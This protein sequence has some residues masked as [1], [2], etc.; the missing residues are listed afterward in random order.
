MANFKEMTERV[1]EASAKVVRESNRVIGQMDEAIELADHA[2]T[3]KRIV[4]NEVKKTIG[5][6]K[7]LFSYFR[8]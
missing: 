5:F 2:I 4:E 1:D 3:T 8:R 7:S 6:F